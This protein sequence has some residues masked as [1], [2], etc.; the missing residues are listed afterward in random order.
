MK[1]EEAVF[2]ITPDH[3]DKP[4]GWPL[5]RSELIRELKKHMIE[6]SYGWPYSIKPGTSVTVK[7]ECG[8]KVVI[9]RNLSYDQKYIQKLNTQ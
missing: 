4:N 1:K 3:H 7:N 5:K 6:R 2:N 9:T 8:K